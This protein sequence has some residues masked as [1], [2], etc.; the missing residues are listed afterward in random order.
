MHLSKRIIIT[1]LIL[2]LPHA[3]VASAQTGSNTAAQEFVT[4]SG[5]KGKVFEVKNREGRALVKALAPLGSGFKGAT[6][7]YSDEFRTLTVRDFPENLA[8]IEEALKRLDTPQSSRS[9]M[10][11]RL[12]ILVASNI[13]GAKNPYPADLNDVVKQLQTTLSYKNYYLLTSTVQRVKEGS[14]QL[15]GDGVA[16]LTPPLV[17][18]PATVFYSF[19]GHSIS[20]SPSA[21]GATNF[22]IN[23]FHFNLRA[24]E[25]RANIRTGL[26]LRDGEKVV[27]GT[28][29]L[30]DKGIIVVLIARTIK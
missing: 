29:T 28:T 6:I 18:K 24:N 7:T 9:D 21:A 26:T 3:P 4:L 22:Q 15:Q 11:L 8:A 20:L 25:E 16:E 23:D 10:E 17:E 2:V 19:I 5:F 30:R 12:Y 14:F 1:A 13:E 27:V